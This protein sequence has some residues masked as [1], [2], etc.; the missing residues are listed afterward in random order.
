MDCW[1]GFMIFMIQVFVVII[2]MRV[3]RIEEDVQKIKELLLEEK[4]VVQRS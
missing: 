3:S 4:T 1:I 2:A